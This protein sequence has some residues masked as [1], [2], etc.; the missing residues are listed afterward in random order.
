MTPEDYEKIDEY[1][2]T[3]W[4]KNHVAHYKTYKKGIEIIDWA[5][6]K[7][8]AYRIS[9]I[10]Y[11][12]YLHVTGDVGDA[13]YQAGLGSLKR[14]SECELGY[15]ASKCVASEQGPGYHEWDSDTLRE[16]VIENMETS[17]ALKIADGEKIEN[18]DSWNLL[19]EKGGLSNMGS[20]FEWGIW[21]ERHGDEFFGPDPYCWPTD[22]KI[23][24]V[25]C[26]GHLIGLQMAIKQLTEKGVIK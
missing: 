1:I 11:D 6:P 18:N 20:Q 21:L 23:I 15:F 13:L 7:R 26:K 8:S 19:R 3:T 16:R 10:E 14:W 25:R 5:N 2:R 22:G 12:S 17:D 9:Y 4:F 24:S